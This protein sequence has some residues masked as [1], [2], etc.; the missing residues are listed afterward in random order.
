ML[1]RR[2]TP[3]VM[4][5]YTNGGQKA[6][7][8]A[9]LGALSSWNWL[10]V[11]E[12]V[13]VEVLNVA[14]TADEVFASAIKD[15]KHEIF[16]AIQAAS[17]P[18]I[19]GQV[20]DGRGNTKVQQGQADLFKWYLSQ[21]LLSILN[22][23]KT[24]LIRDIVDLN[25]V[26]PHY[27]K[28]SLSAVDQEEVAAELRNYYTG[29]EM[30]LDFS[31]AELYEKFGW[32]PPTSKEDCLPGK[33]AAGAGGAGGPQPPDDGSPQP[34]DD[35]GDQQGQQDQGDSFSAYRSQEV[36]GNAGFPISKEWMDWIRRRGKA[37]RS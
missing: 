37:T 36:A 6:T 10:S 31:K 24:G 2:A 27:P 28:A 7:L 12:S 14:G 16:L 11:P 21:S 20:S 3:I 26:T 9:A 25:Y 22:D 5:T 34:P 4:G 15:Y 17:L 35:Q 32:K 1:E 19:E 8:D 29:W 33:P 18:N 23:R 30:G 13:R